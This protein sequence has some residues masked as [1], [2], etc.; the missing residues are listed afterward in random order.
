MY[1]ITPKSFIFFTNTSNQPR[2]LTV[3]IFNSNYNFIT[4]YTA[5]RV[6]FEPDYYSCYNDDLLWSLQQLMVAFEQNK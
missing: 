1:A 5:T 3:N 6:T 2:S 4:K